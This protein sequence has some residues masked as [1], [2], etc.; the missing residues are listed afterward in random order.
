MTTDRKYIEKNPTAWNSLSQMIHDFSSQT[1]DEIIGSEK[2]SADSHEKMTQL[3]STNHFIP[4]LCSTEFETAQWKSWQDFRP[5]STFLDRL[6][7]EDSANE[8]L[9]SNE[10]EQFLLSRRRRATKR[11]ASSKIIPTTLDIE[12][13]ESDAEHHVTVSPTKRTRGTHEK[14]MPLIFT[15]EAFPIVSAEPISKPIVT[16]SS[17]SEAQYYK[18]LRPMTVYKRG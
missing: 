11:Q 5:V 1:L 4:A 3:N 2:M 18:N 8:A 7:Q 10:S 13:S 9:S 12:V 16:E 17:D 14:T 15:S 6:K